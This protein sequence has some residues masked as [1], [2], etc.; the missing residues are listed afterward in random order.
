MLPKKRFGTGRCPYC[1]MALRTELARQC[2]HCKRDWHESAETPVMLGTNLPAGQPIAEQRSG[3]Y[4]LEVG[5]FAQYRFAWYE[6]I[7]ARYS[8]DCP[9]CPEC[10]GAVG[11]LYWLEPR[12]VRLKQA[13]RIG[14]FV[15]G[16]GG[17]DL[18]VSARFLSAYEAEGLKG[19]Q[20][21]YPV[22]VRLKTSSRR[23][24]SPP[25]LHGV[26]FVHSRT[27]VKTAETIWITLPSPGSCRV[28]GPDGGGEINGGSY[29]FR[30]LSLEPDTWT[31]E[32]LFYAMNRSGV[33]LVS[34]KAAAFIREYDF[35]NCELTP[36]EVFSTK[37]GW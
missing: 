28:C 5:M 35:T 3:F 20:R 23:Q 33:I 19:I 27:R 15:A 18:L 37:Y 36:I 26:E 11:S 9:K 12:I 13:R 32:D 34:P 10:G 29:R 31:G 24:D 16:A 17:A 21:H 8:D 7:Y 1:G 14:D 22:E 30:Y 2:R 25:A 6:P 4:V